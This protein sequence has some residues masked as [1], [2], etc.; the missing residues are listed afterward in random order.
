MKVHELLTLI[1]MQG[2]HAAP[3][4]VRFGFG[5]GE[6]MGTVVD[7]Y[8]DEVDDGKPYAVLV[9]MVGVEEEE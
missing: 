1:A 8:T 9:L 4:E 3:V 7:V 5:D 2:L 6:D